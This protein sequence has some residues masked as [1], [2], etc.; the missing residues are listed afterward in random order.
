[1]ETKKYEINFDEF[2]KLPLEQEDIENFK[3]KLGN[4]VYYYKNNEIIGCITFTFIEYDT[5]FIS[6]IKKSEDF[7]KKMLYDGNLFI[8][9]FINNK[10]KVC[11]KL[12]KDKE[13]VIKMLKKRYKTVLEY[14]NN[15][16]LIK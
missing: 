9:E 4:N 3:K 5:V 11:L 14:D 12:N 6:M 8:K 10:D 2:S 13:K 7:P 1:M 16:V 15:V